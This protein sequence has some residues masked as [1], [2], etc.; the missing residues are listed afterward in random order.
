M[1]DCVY[2]RLHLPD[3][4][5]AEYAQARMQARFGA[6][7]DAAV[8][9]ELDG[10]RNLGAYLEAVKGTALR[11]WIGGIDAGA[12]LHQ[13]E[14][15]LRERLRGHIREVAQWL[16]PEWRAAALWT[17]QLLDLPALVH[18]LSGHAAHSWM[19][20]E[21]ALSGIAAGAPGTP[22]EAPAFLL[23]HR[24]GRRRR[25]PADAPALGDARAAWLAEWERRWP[26]GNPE[27]DA[28]LRQ[29]AAA[30]SAHLARF[31]ETDAREGWHA[32]A[33]LERELRRLFRRL[34]LRP[35]AA[36]PYLGL[37]ALDLERLRAQ[38]VRRVLWQRQGTAA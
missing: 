12:D 30:I 16:P 24:A 18:L 27:S 34:A 31:K 6:R 21:P 1:R 10:I 19:S 23:R 20:R 3:M 32:R 37:A 11:R 8:W 26:A 5:G 28:G 17:Q 9:R 2:R 35:E 14:A 38:L 13:I 33:A 29:T 15:G 22:P 4:S 25:V 36:F 7:P